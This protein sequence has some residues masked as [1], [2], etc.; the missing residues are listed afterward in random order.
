[1]TMQYLISCNFYPQKKY[2]SFEE[3]VHILK[4]SLRV[5]RSRATNIPFRL[6][7]LKPGPE[8]FHP[9]MVDFN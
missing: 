9:E 7:F 1:M 4:S 2:F 8:T 5:E 3:Y 6:K